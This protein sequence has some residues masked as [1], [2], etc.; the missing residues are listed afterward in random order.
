MYNFTVI[1]KITNADNGE[2]TSI[3]G[4]GTVSKGTMSKGIESK[5]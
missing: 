3:P 5:N 4:F 1:I 2:E